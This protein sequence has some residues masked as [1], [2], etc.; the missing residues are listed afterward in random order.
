MELLRN[1]ERVQVKVIEEGQEDK[2][3]FINLE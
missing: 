2:I 3:N 1:A